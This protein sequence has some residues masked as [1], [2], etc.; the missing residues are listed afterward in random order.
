M[1]T[2]KRKRARASA[3]YLGA[4]LLLLLTALPFGPV[5]SRAKR[6]FYAAAP[7]DTAGGGVSVERVELRGEDYV[8][9]GRYL[10]E[11]ILWQVIASDGGCPLLF[12]E[13][14][15]CLKAFAADEKPNEASSDWHSS[16]LRQW[17]NCAQTRVQ[18]DGAPPGA[19][20]LYGGHNGYADEPGFLSEGNFSGQEAALIKRNGDAVFLLTKKQLR[21]LPAARRRKALTKAAR[22]QDD[23]PYWFIRPYCWYWTADPIATNAQSVCSVTTKGSFYKS[24]AADGLNGVCPALYLV[25][26]TVDSAG[27]DGSRA[28]PYQLVGRKQP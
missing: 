17:L 1:R 21:K 4:A 5:S 14:V 18:W 3:C 24:L 22:G 11:P 7:P 26:D 13:Y 20:N 16:A 15:L 12:S 6:A 10:G 28:A 2:L 8:L 19:A 23:S 27:G 25:S 9:F